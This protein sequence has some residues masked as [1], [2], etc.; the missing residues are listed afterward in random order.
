MPHSCERHDSLICTTWLIHR[1]LDGMWLIHRGF[2]TP[3]SS[4]H[5][6]SWRSIPA[7]PSSLW[8]H[9]ATYYNTL[10]HTCPIM[11]MSLHLTT[12]FL[13]LRQHTATHG[14]TLQHTATAGSL[15]FWPQLCQIP[16]KLSHSSSSPPNP[17]LSTHIF[18]SSEDAKPCAENGSC[19]DFTFFEELFFVLNSS[20]DTHENKQKTDRKTAK[21]REA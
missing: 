2:N 6:C 18:F 19:S 3:R 13:N 4:A 20:V 17:L 9:T 21:Q 5:S 8:Q 12:A 14:N 11:F 15:F 1:G 7:A 10:Q 16:L